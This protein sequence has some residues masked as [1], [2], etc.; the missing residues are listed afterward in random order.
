M[1]EDLFV[2]ITYTEKKSAS[3]CVTGGGVLSSGLDTSVGPTLEADTDNDVMGVYESQQT[4]AGQ[5]NEEKKEKR[6][7]AADEPPK[8]KRRGWRG[9]L[10]KVFRCMGFVKE[11]M[12]RGGAC[13]A[14]SMC[15]VDTVS[16]AEIV[17]PEQDQVLSEAAGEEEDMGSDSTGRS[18][19]HTARA[20]CECGCLEFVRD[21]E[22]Q[23]S[24]LS[25][26][27]RKM[28]RGFKR[29]V[30]FGKTTAV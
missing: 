14:R 26:S 11:P 9:V 27:A 5:A 12:R 8:G 30:C 25:R 29:S 28:G 10:S 20:Q 24:W 18:S 1:A 2:D 23:R 4:H 19:Y 16:L 13:I 3:G 22:F 6:L 15:R 21:D 7:N 17:D